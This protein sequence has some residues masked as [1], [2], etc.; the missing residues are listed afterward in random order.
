T[1]TF[2]PNAG[3][4]ATTASQ[5][6]TVNPAITPS[7]NSIAPICAGATLTALPTTSNEGIIGTWTP[8]L[9]NTATTTYT[10]TPNAGQCATLFSLT[11]E[12]NELPIFTIEGDCEGDEYVLRLKP[13]PQ[14]ITIA[15]FYE[16]T[17]I[18]TNPIFLGNGNF[19]V[20]DQ[21]GIYRAV[22]SNDNCENE[23]SI[24]VEDN[25]CKIPK[26]VSANNDGLNDTFDLSNLKVKNLK[27]FNRYGTVVYEKENYKDEWDGKSSH[28]NHLPDGTYYYYI[29][30]LNGKAK[31]GWVYLTHEL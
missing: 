17:S 29:E 26:G 5:T 15:W 13:S 22:Y 3:Q 20:A 21:L 1:Y 7:F 9:N 6:I 30:F 4:C 28:G 12:V 16:G 11:L 10:F 14:N 25:Y 8:A 19:T 27:I 18:G 24:F 31:T 23:N 2:T